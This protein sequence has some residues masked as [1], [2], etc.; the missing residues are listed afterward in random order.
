MSL[1]RFLTYSNQLDIEGLV[2]TTSIH[3]KNKTAAWRIK[4]IVSAYG[5]VRDNLLL[6]EK[7]YPTEEY[8]QSIIKEGL[9][10]YGLEA[11]GDDKDSLGSELLI[12]SME[13]NDKR[14]LWIL[15]SQI[16]YGLISILEVKDH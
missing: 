12:K 5:K 15:V 2:A 3:L 14:T 9:P 10:L 4:D 7:G 16:I 6:H 1:V 13:A 8:L 11:V